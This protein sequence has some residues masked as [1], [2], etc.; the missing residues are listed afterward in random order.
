MPRGRI[1]VPPPA[2]GIVIT[3]APLPVV[4]EYRFT[5]DRDRQLNTRSVPVYSRDGFFDP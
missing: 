3:A 2:T 1:T 4:V 5:Q